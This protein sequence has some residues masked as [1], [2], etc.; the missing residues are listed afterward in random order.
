MFALAQAY[1]AGVIT[2]LRPSSFHFPLT[3]RYVGAVALVIAANGAAFLATDILAA[4]ALSMVFLLAVLATGAGLGLGPALCAALLAGLTYNFLHIEPRHT[5]AIARPAEALTFVVFAVAAL[6]TGML[7]GRVRD[8]ARDARR[9]SRRLAVLLEA[10]QRLGAAPDARSTAYALT[11]QIRTA[12]GAAAVLLLPGPDGLVLAGGPPGLDRLGAES[13]ET[14]SG[15]WRSAESAAGDGWAFERIDGSHG[16]VA[17]VGLR[18]ARPDL[19]A[20]SVVLLDAL[21]WQGAAALDRA[22]LAHAAAE[23]L[24]LRE[25]DQLRAAILNS[26]S[27]DFRTPLST[28]LGAATTLLDYGTRLTPDVR[29]DLLTSIREDAERLNRHVGSLLDM[30]RLEGRALVA[31]R[32]LLDVADIADAALRRIESRLAGRVVRR[33]LGAGL[34]PVCGDALLLEQALVNLLDNALSHTQVGAVLT[35]AI[36]EQD[37]GITLAVEDD[38]PGIPSD[39]QE[40]IFEKFRRLRTATDRSGGLGL[41][42]SIVNGFMTAMGGRAGILSPV[43]GGRGSRFTLWLPQAGGEETA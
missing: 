13:L 6:V 31:R 12:T 20:A 39:A 40:V 4:D 28:V 35:V 10:S 29:R 42:L 7:S 15:V 27:H 21:L 22:A 38:G 3:G 24:A 37:G 8:Q 33:V 43:A 2:R 9:Q 41:G 19:A 36:H 5:L 32:D 16:P 18:Q 34:P 30:S 23:N 17:V 26:I 14:A 11:E 25:A 1:T